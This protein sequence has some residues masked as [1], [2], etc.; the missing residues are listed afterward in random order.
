[1]QNGPIDELLTEQSTGTCQDGEAGLEEAEVSLTAASLPGL[2][3]G[4]QCSAEYTARKMIGRTGTGW[5][6]GQELAGQRE[7]AAWALGVHRPSRSVTG[8]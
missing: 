7:K 2:G 8:T 5:V 6:R 4:P 3:L 1:M